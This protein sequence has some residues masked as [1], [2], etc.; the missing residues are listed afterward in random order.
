MIECP[1]ANHAPGPFYTRR[2]WTCAR[3]PSH[4]PAILTEI[5][6]TKVTGVGGIFFK[7][8][9]PKALAAWYRDN[10]GFN[11]EDWGGVQFEKSEAS[12]SVLVWTPFRQDTDHFAPSSREFMLNFVVDD[13]DGMI[14][15]LA[16][17]GI[18]ILKRED[19]DTFGRFAWLLDPAGMKIELWEPKPES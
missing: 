6:M 7:C 11:V 5:D 16:A 15:E 13:L 8:A 10:F 3:C 12:P 4:H 2:Q 17:K 19:A 18:A 9:D 1:F 14:A